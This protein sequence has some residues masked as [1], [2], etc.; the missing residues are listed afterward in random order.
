[1]YRRGL[2]GYLPANITSGIVGLLTIVVFTRLMTPQEYGAYALAMTVMIL[3]HT[4]LF[5]WTEAAMARFQARAREQG[6]IAGHMATIYRTWLFLALAFPL[7]TLKVTAGIHWEA[8]KLW[9]KR[10]PLFRKPPPP[11]AHFT[12]GS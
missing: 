7:V 8:L 9:V 11:E 4:L 1:M 10:V 12:A 2:L 3:A 5:T 6:D